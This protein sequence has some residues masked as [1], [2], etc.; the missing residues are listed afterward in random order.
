MIHGPPVRHVGAASMCQ[1]IEVIVPQRTHQL[2][3]VLC[4]RALAVVRVIAR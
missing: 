4:H 2:Q 3:H 1:Y